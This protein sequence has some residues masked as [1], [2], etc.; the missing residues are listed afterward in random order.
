MHEPAIRMLAECT[1]MLSALYPLSR[2]AIWLHLAG[3]QSLRTRCPAPAPALVL[4]SLPDSWQHSVARSRLSTWCTS[5][6]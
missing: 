5:S 1:R 3:V 4:E 6:I 2:L